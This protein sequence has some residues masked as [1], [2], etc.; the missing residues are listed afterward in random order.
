MH[1]YD[2]PQ[3][4]IVYATPYYQGALYDGTT[5]GT[6]GAATGVTTAA[7]CYRIEAGIDNIA[8]H[9]MKRTLDPGLLS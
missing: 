5:D 8:R 3:N 7:Q 4:C 2:I 1:Y 9:V 6:T